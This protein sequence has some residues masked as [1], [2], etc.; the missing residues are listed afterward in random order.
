M[1]LHKMFGAVDPIQL[2]LRLLV[3]NG[4]LLLDALAPFLVDGNDALSRA[5]AHPDP[6]MDALAAASMALADE[7]A[8][9]PPADVHAR[10]WRLT[11]EAAGQPLRAPAEVSAPAV[12]RLTESWFCCA[13]PS[14]RQRAAV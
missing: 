1:Q 12:P 10:L 2:A 13:E 6:R 5:W 7:Q 9:A 11:A 8:D 4:S 3:P 14:A